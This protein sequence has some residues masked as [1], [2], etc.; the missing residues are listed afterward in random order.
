MAMMLLMEEIT[1]SLENGEYVIGVFLDFSKAF[2][3]VDHDI[4]LRKLHHYGIRG[5][6]L[7]WFENYLKNRKQFVTYNGVSSDTKLI[8]CGVPQG[9]IL[10]PLLFFIYI[11]DLS[12]VCDRLLSILFADDTNM[13]MSSKDVHSLQ[14]VI[15][16][17]LT[18]VSKWLKGNKLSLNI[19]KNYDI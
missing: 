7:R 6:A 10:G 11:D 16:Q 9:S 1:K 4:L 3:T 15:N 13:F 19:K 12:L 18:L 17:E 5:N 14:T 2:D 8:T